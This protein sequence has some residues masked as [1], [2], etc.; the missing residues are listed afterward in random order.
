MLRTN[1]LGELRASDADKAV[2]LIGWVHRRRDH[3]GIIFLDLRDRYGLTQVAFHPENKEAFAAADKI[4]PEWVV[5]VKGKV[6]K[7]PA[8]AL[9]KGLPTGEIEVEGEEIVDSWPA[10]TPP[11]EIENDDP[12]NE[13]IR[14]KH[15]YLD[16]RREGLQKRIIF[17]SQVAQLVRE[18]LTKDDFVEVETPLLANSSPEGARDYLVPSRI[19]EG[20]FYALPQAPQQFKQLLMIGGLDRYFQ[21]A[22]ALRDEDL[23][24]DRQPEHTQVDIEMSFVEE[25]DVFT[26]VENLYKTIVSKLSKKKLSKNAFEK[27]PYR[28][29][30]DRYGSDK[31]DL[32]I[33]GLE[34]H[35]VT[36]IVKASEFGVFNGAEQIKCIVA[37]GYADSSRGKI[38]E[39]TE[40][41]KEDGAKGLAWLKVPKAGEFDA[42]ILKYISPE[43]QKQLHAELKTKA[44]DLVLF[45]A[46]TP[47]VVARVLSSLRNTIGHEIG[48][49]EHELAF[50]W[51]TNFPMYEYDEDKKAWDFGHNPFTK[52]DLINGKMDPEILKETDAAGIFGCQYDI[53]CN[54]YELGS[55][56]IRNNDMELLKA[57]F[58]KVGY[59]DEYFAKHFGKF[60]KAFEYG[61]PP[62]GGIALGFDRF[63]MLLTDQPNIREVIA[64]PKSQK[65]ED[66]MLGAPMSATAEQLRDLHIKLDE[67]P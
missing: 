54:G 12:V 6:V 19:H 22:R 61:A 48:V 14:L 67:K 3:G 31:P 39:L 34:L 40:L 11:F 55:G 25:E 58:H 44:G 17:R 21:L 9:N 60:A 30:M 53:I 43:I 15:R 42:P 51:I 37:P 23:R 1:T 16:L 47:A 8:D 24:G 56:S 57:A 7:R 33:K 66:P 36:K 41:A 26:V 29:A 20:K 5:Q 32:R 4:R 64:F 52:P 45:S 18:T 65:A 13:E 38:D 46:D 35:D 62:H 50:A 27:I 63:V 10:K 2:T 49:D 59:D 28:E